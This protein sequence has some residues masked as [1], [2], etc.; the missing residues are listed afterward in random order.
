MASFTNRFNPKKET[1]G[2]HRCLLSMN[3]NH[4][5]SLA[6]ATSAEEGLWKI[7]AIRPVIVF[8]G[9]SYPERSVECCSDQPLPSL[10]LVT[11][12]VR[13]TN[14]CQPGAYRTPNKRGHIPCVFP[15][16]DTSCSRGEEWDTG[17]PPGIG[18]ERHFLCPRSY[19]LFFPSLFVFT[20]FIFQSIST[21]H[22]A[23]FSPHPSHWYCEAGSESLV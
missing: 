8:L 1:L 2:S 16:E 15:H 20:V 9:G 21:S 7:A 12:T 5:R 11:H 4:R 17:N 14:D 13:H 23:S 19:Q 22:S 10:E 18:W 3:M 6:R